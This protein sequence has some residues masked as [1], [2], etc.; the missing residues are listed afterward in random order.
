M[1]MKLGET[2]NAIRSFAEAARRQP[3]YAEAQNNLSCAIEA[4]R[5]G[6]VGE[7]H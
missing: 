2:D 5:Q 1:Q 3:G 4:K 7:K 6:D